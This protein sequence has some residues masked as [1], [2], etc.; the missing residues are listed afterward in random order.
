MQEKCQRV[1]AD[2]QSPLS[3][4]KKESYEIVLREKAIRIIHQ[5]DAFCIDR[6]GYLW[7]YAMVI[8]PT[9]FFKINRKERKGR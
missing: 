7:R 3:T 9:V 1:D 8:N 5:G 2:P 6:A 4:Y